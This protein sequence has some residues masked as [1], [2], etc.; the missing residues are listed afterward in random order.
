MS[1]NKKT[2][3]TVA[4]LSFFMLVF[5]LLQ[6]LLFSSTN[7]E[8]SKF[9]VHQNIDS[10]ILDSI[11]KENIILFFGYV[12]CVDVCTPLLHEL[13]AMYVSKAFHGLEESTAIVF[14]NLIPE[15]KSDQPQLFATSFNEKFIG[16]HLNK[17]DLYSIDRAFS[18]FYTP[19][20]SNKNEL[21]HSDSIYLLKKKDSRL[22]LEN[23]YMTHPLNTTQL[24]QDIKN[25]S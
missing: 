12:G 8:S 4:F 22:V 17:R 11:E 23:I 6:N 20:L 24:I 19:S 3:F 18:L 5:L 25:N 9:V 21:S 7:L 16:L 2:S 10:H 15:L 14:V 13:N 1:V